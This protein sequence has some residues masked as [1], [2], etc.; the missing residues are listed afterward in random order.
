[1][2]DPKPDHESLSD[3]LPF[4][5]IAK[6]IEPS[7]NGKSIHVATLGR[8]RDPGVRSR[9]GKSMIRLRCTRTPSGWRTSVDAVQEFFNALTTDRTDRP[10]PALSI[11]MDPRRRREFERAKRELE[12]AGI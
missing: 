6:L 9:D 12:D 1:M 2:N 8:W 7:R 3:L 4:S 10:D 5:R 11:C